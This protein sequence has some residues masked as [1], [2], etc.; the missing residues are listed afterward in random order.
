MAK[1]MVKDQVGIYDLTMKDRVGTP[2][3][4]D[5]RSDNDIATFIGSYRVYQKNGSRNWQMAMEMKDPIR[6]GRDLWQHPAM[7]N[8]FE[9]SGRNLSEKRSKGMANEVVLKDDPRKLLLSGP[10]YWPP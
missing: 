1:V 6:K 5:P 4:D 7:A 2:L 10:I 8:G 3:K 9:G